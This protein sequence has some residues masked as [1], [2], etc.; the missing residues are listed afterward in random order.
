MSAFGETS[1]EGGGEGNEDEKLKNATLN[2]LKV[3]EKNN[4]KYL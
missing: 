4:L 3:A 2:S 1:P